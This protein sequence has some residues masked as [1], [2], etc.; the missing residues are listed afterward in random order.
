M[1]ANEFLRESPESELAKKLPSLKKHDYDTIDRLMTKVSEKHGITGKKLHD[2]FVKKYGN[3][4]DTWVK[5]L[6]EASLAQ[7]RKEL[8]Q[9]DKTNN[10]N[11]K[12]YYGFDEYEKEKEKEEKSKKEREEEKRPRTP[13]KPWPMQ[14]RES[15]E[16]NDEERDAHIYEFIE[17]C[18]K[19]LKIQNPPEF[20]LSYDTEEAQGNHHTGEHSG[21][22]IWVYVKNR[23]LIDILRTV[24]HELTHQRQTE[25]GMIKPGDSYPGS[26]IEML[27]D[28]VAGKYIKVWGKKHPEIFQ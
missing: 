4:P 13:V 6:D 5:K 17:W 3:T 24:L 27:A 26:P 23:N 20:E 2:L 10:L 16:L 8:A 28:M 25:L 22:R 7:M 21:N 14:M 9:M 11:R 12:V 18:Y 15:V 1:R 19:L